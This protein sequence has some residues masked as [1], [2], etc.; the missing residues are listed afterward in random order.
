M[1]DVVQVPPEGVIMLK[2]AWKSQNLSRSSTVKKPQPSQ[3]YLYRD[4]DWDIEVDLQN[5]IQ[6]RMRMYHLGDLSRRGCTH[7]ELI[8]RVK[9]NQ[10]ALFTVAAALEAKYKLWKDME[11]IVPSNHFNWSK[12]GDLK[13]IY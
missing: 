8:G 11:P 12:F 13:Q 10:H 5:S 7:K 9:Y 2:A 1:L 6:P 4:L 3:S